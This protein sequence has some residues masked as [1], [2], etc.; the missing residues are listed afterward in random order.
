VIAD[1]GDDLTV[2]AGRFFLQPHEIPD[3]REQFG[4]RS[5]ASPVWIRT[6]S[7]PV[8]GIVIDHACGTQDIPPGGKIAM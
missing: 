2:G 3:D 6:T 4:P 1:H 5:T 7:P 8:S